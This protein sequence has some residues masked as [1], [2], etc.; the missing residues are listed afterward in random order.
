MTR[1]LPHIGGKAD[2]LQ[3]PRTGKYITDMFRNVHLLT[4]NI[5]NSLKPPLRMSDMYVPIMNLPSPRNIIST[6]T[7]IPF[8]HVTLSKDVKPRTL[9]LPKG[10]LPRIIVERTTKICSL[11]GRCIHVTIETRELDRPYI[12]VYSWSNLDLPEKGDGIIT[13]LP[14][15][16][17]HH[18]RE[19]EKV[20]LTVIDQSTS[21]PHP[22]KIRS[23]LLRTPIVLNDVIMVAGIKFRVT[24]LKPRMAGRVS[25]R[26]RVFLVRELE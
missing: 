18:L 21:L 24:N 8:V 26:T 25:N 16:H 3:K 5:I 17:L 14:L 23:L 15:G 1:T 12:D 20:E 4:S 6:T 10:V 2:I 13:V 22:N 7:R 19:L 11:N 9:L